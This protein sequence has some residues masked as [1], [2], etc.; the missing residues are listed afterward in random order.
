M[1][2]AYLHE[3]FPDPTK[4]FV[5]REVAAMVALGMAP[6]V[7]SIRRPTAEE[8]ARME[9]IDF[10]VR[11]LPEEADCGRR[12]NA[13]GHRFPRGNGARY[14]RGEGTRGLDPGG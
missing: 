3:C 1:S 8:A 2:F 9:A 14:R 13:N 5:Y 11:Y 7:F 10:A 12:S 4:T 6:V